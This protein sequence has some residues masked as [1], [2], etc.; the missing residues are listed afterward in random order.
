MIWVVIFLVLDYFSYEVSCF[1]T[2]LH[3]RV[4]SRSIKHHP[5]S[6]KE[7]QKGDEEAGNIF[8]SAWKGIK[9]FLP[10]VTRAKIDQT[11]ETP[12]YESG[13]R[14]SIRLLQ[15]DKKFKRHTITRIRRYLP[16]IEWETAESIVDDA[17]IN[18]ISLIRV[19]NSLV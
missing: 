14:Y 19:V 12:E 7:Q 13:N 9:R 16:D 8:N 18:G 10:G 6:F 2:V 1:Q 11:Y 3:T 17:I 4:K 15:P 5:L